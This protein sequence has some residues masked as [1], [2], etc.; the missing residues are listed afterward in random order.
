MGLYE[1][2]WWDI[3]C[4][5]A[6]ENEKLFL[7]RSEKKFAQGKTIASLHVS[8]G[9]PVLTVNRSKWTTRSCYTRHIN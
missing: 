2:G 4:S 1:G 3:A 6:C 7:V 9:P 5:F 8:S